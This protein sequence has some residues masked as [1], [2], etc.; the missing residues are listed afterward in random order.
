MH[1]VR[2]L[3]NERRWRVQTRRP[4]NDK[5]VVTVQTQ[6]KET[7]CFSFHSCPGS[8]SP[9]PHSYQVGQRYHVREGHRAGITGGDRMNKPI[10][11]WCL[12]HRSPSIYGYWITACG[13][14]CPE[15][16]NDKQIFCSCGKRIRHK[17]AEK[18]SEHCLWVELKN[19]V[20]VV[21]CFL[22]HQRDL[23]RNICLCGRKIKRIR[24]T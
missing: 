2:Y 12:R 16:E 10:K 3:K 18:V 14:T 24:P 6:S 15:Y 11:K 22:G 9:P 7:C 8:G 17:K 23:G 1:Q 4:G 20:Y 19:G 5:R 21:D 13:V